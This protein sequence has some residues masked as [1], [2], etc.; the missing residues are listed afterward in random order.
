M[1]INIQNLIDDAR[2]YEA[3]RDLRWP[4]KVRCPH[5]NAEECLGRNEK[6][7]RYLLQLALYDSYL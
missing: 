1:K 7:R 6:K 3:V 2:C 5:C 4:G